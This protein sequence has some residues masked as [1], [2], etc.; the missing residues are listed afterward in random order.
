MLGQMGARHKPGEEAG[1]GSEVWEEHVDEEGTPF[2]HNAVTGETTWHNPGQQ[3]DEPAD[4]WEE[5][6]A[7]GMVFYLN[8][9]TGET[10]RHKPG[11]DED[12]EADME[13]GSQ[14]DEVSV[15]FDDVFENEDSDDRI[16]MANPMN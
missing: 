7:D 11:L 9:E 13:T 6:E 15:D 2:Y 14:E 5:H 4:V 10:S 8:T 12:D 1:R 3:Q 16:S